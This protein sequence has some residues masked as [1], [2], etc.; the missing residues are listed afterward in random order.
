A[1]KLISTQ[2]S[3]LRYI[4]RELH[5]E[6]GQILTAIGSMLS[7]SEKYA[8]EASILRSD[9]RE[10]RDIT[11]TALDKV[12]ALSQAL[13]P[14]MLEE[15]GLENTMDWYITTVEKQTGLAISY[16][17]SGTAFPLDGVA[18]VHI[19][20]VLQ[21][22][23]NNVA[24]HSGAQQAWVRL[25][26]SPDKLELEVEDHGAGFVQGAAK[27][28]IGLVAMRERAELLGGTI[29]F[30]QPAIGGTLIRLSVPKV[31]MD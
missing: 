12:R 14:V 23:L 20:R 5:D 11:Q 26:F 24:R 9:L 31:R 19:Y 13:H 7:R 18:S 17:K 21:E 28:G 10:V 15:S 1:Q 30:V 27:P 16:E 4:S 3:T 22:A 6:F 29:E 25:R 8:P 2:E